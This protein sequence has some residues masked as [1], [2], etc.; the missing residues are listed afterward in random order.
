L[1]FLA[2]LRALLAF[3][4]IPS[5]IAAFIGFSG[6]PIGIIGDPANPPWHSALLAFPAIPP[7]FIGISGKPPGQRDE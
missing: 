5:R 6:D 4:A 3:S 7:A 2:I 1:A